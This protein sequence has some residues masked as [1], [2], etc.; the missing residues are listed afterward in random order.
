[1]LITLG[2]KD[3]LRVTESCVSKGLVEEKVG[4]EPNEKR[5]MLCASR[6]VLDGW[7]VV[8]GRINEE[9]GLRKDV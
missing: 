8:V 7:P 5:D 2:T 4:Q 3:D 6:V 1:M 9:Y